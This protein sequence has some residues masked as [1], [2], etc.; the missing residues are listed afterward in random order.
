MSKRSIALLAIAFAAM[1]ACDD[2]PE[3]GRN[4][5]SILEFNGGAPVQ[6][7]VL[8]DNGTDPAY[9]AEDL[10]PVIFQSRPYNAL[11]TGTT[12]NQVMIDSYHIAWT[13]T[14]GGSGALPARDESSNIY[15]TTGEETD[16]VIRLVTWGDKSGPILSGLIGSPNQVG[17]RADITF[18][19]REV[20][21]EEEFEV[22][23]SISVNFSDAVNLE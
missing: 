12:H 1:V 4:V 9:V 17:M 10:I 14:D 21:T 11:V 7:D 2:A 15:I 6:S 22:Q 3:S 18:H 8:V 20:G 13:R 5:V 23:A 16:A 19:G